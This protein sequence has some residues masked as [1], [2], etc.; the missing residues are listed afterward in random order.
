MA[1]LADG[2]SDSAP[3]SDYFDA[4]TLGGAAALKRPD[5]GRLEP[6]AQ[7]DIVAFSLSDFRDGVTD[8][9]LRTL[10]LNGSARN[11]VHSVVAGRTVMANGTLP[12]VD[13]P[14][15]A[16][17]AQPIFEKMRAAYSERDWRGRSAEEL[18]PASYPAAD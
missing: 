14:A 17:A 11:A 2:R 6:G 9:P 5:L 13:L 3:A 18:F 7:A 4:A 16:A 10:L 1:K 15:L 8:D 12:G